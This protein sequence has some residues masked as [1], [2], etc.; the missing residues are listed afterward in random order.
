MKAYIEVRNNN[1]GK[2][3]FAND[4]QH[5]D[6]NGKVDSHLVDIDM[7]SAYGFAEERKAWGY[8]A[9]RAAVKAY[10]FAA[11]TGRTWTYCD[12]QLIPSDV[13]VVYLVTA[14]SWNVHYY[15][16]IL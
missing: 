5:V 9:A 12:Y 16:V 11:D 7:A 2:C 10:N 1:G 6:F 14:W 4:V 3:G 15:V 8:D 13:G